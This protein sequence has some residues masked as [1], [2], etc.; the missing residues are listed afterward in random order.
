MTKGT[1]GYIRYKKSRQ[2]LWTGVIAAIS[3]GL[4][5]CG[6]FA[7]GTTKNLLTVFAV[8][9]VLPGAKA[10]VNGIVFAPYKSLS[11]ETYKTF[12]DAAGENGILYSDLVFTSSKSIMHLDALYVNG[13]ELVGYSENAKD[14]EK[15]EILSYFTDSCKKRGTTVHMH[16]FETEKEMTERI[17]SLRERTDE[18]P[19]VVTEFIRM[20]L[21]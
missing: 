8:L 15:K 1:N 6:Y 11:A 4:F 9:G 17:E 18:I 19:E 7:T 10:L 2:F 5:L 12:C 16:I 14:K 13:T 21:V 3:V 20:I